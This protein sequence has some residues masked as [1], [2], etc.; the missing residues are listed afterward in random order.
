MSDDDAEL[1]ALI[2]NELDE[3]R[4]TALLA[5]LAADEG[6]R[7]RYEELWETTA[8]LAAS[9]TPCFSRLRSL[10]YGRRF[11]LA[12]QFG[13]RK[14]VL[15]ELLSARWPPALSL[16]RLC[17]ELPYGPRQ[18]SGCSTDGRIDA[19]L[20]PNTHIFTQTRPSAR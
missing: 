6:L 18:A 4:K 8:S 16:E 7:E 2:D 20:S 3:G 12:G 17:R 9:S 5:R 10:I 1:V 13:R 15:P 14:G 19:R 11:P